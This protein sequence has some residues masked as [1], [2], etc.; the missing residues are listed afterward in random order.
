MEIKLVLD[1][2]LLDEYAEYYF[3]NHT[4]ARMRAI[5]KPRHPSINEW[6]IMKRPQMN[7][8]KQK[9]KEFIIWWIEKLEYT[10]LKLDSFDIIFTV[11]F[12]TKRRV[13]PDNQDPKFILDGFTASGFIVDDSSNHLHSLTLRCDYDKEWPRTEILI[14]VLDDKEECL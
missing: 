12:D 9:W 2:A 5:D 7:A 1:N 11:F 4:K 10:D 3:D 8:L 6:M 14:T 13:D